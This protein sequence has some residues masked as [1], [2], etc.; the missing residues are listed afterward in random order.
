MRPLGV[1]ILSFPKAKNRSVTTSYCCLIESTFR[2]SLD[3]ETASC[4]T[5]A[6]RREEREGEEREEGG[7]REGEEREEG[8]GGEGEGKI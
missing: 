2:G 3:G 1:S 6:T 4:M 8:D 5:V 7:E